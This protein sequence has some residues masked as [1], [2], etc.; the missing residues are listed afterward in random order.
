MSV[1]N[2]PLPA[3]HPTPSPPSGAPGRWPV[4]PNRQVERGSSLVGRGPE[5]ARVEGFVARLGAG[6]PSLVLVG[7]AGIGKTTLWRHGVLLARSAGARV[8]LAR[9]GE[10]DRHSPAQG[11]LDLFGATGPDTAARLS[12]PD[13][14]V[15]ERSRLVLDVLRRLAGDVP[16]V[17][18]VDD[19]PWLDDPTGRALRFAL[20]RLVDEPVALLATARTWGP[21]TNPLGDVGR[22]VETLV[23]DP[24]PPADL[25]RI[26]MAAVPRATVPLA[27][28]SGDLARGNP[29]LAIE[30]ARARVAGS[31]AAPEGSALA[32]VTRRLHQLP[33]PALA[34]ARLLAVAGPTGLPVL[35]AASGSGDLDDALRAGLDGDAFVLEPDFVLRFAH[36]LLAAAVL[37]GLNAVDRRDLHAA[38]AGVVTDPDERAAHLA[39]S[40]TAPDSGVAGEVEAAALRL[41]RRGAP[42]PAADLL[43]HSAR[44]TPPGEPEAHLRRVLAQM[45]QCATAGDLPA[46]LKLAGG[47]LEH[48]P[49]GPL[50]AAAVTGRVVL[51]FSDG[52]T[53]LREALSG[54]PDDGDPGHERLRG[55]LLG[56]LGWLLAVHLGRV[57]EGLDHAREGLRIGR[58]HGD[59]VLVA[60]AASAVSTAS[61]VQG[62]RADDLVDEAVRLGSEVVASHLALWPRVLRGRQRLWDGRLEQ[63][64]C[65]LEA[66]Y[67]SAVASGSEFQ[68]PYRLCDLAHVALAEGDLSR[69][70]REVGEGLEAARDCR[71]ERVESWLAYPAGLVAALRR[72]EDTAEQAADRLRWWATRTGERPRE[73]MAD[74]VRGVQAAAARDWEAALEHLVRSVSRLDDLG[75]VHPG[76]VPVLPPAIEAA[77]LAGRRDDAHA[78]LHALRRRCSGLASPWAD[79]ILASARGQVLLLHDDPAALDVLLDARAR[80]ARTGHALDA[81]RTGVVAA[82][83]A[84]RAGRRRSV[85]E[86]GGDALETFCRNGVRG[87]DGL[88]RELLDRAGGATD[89]ELTATEAEVAAL[90][91]DGLRNREVGVRMFVSEST[92][93]AHLTRIYRKLGVRNRAGLSRHVERGRAVPGGPEELKAS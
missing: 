24:V 19:L 44:L 5:R 23:V 43:S 76:A 3:S 79:A 18:A 16:V 68:R 28:R 65:D 55:R 40:V 11:L 93:E 37:G 67:A 42:Q 64:R 77:C 62:E 73:A 57:A 9:P 41:A 83:A 39:R 10:D 7:D 52:E 35:C 38:L 49:P 87:Y 69:A 48:L 17:L 80:L 60:Q 31:T 32:A 45:K 4:A 58:L 56:L 86:L 91:A 63:A 88:A 6:A 26:V 14:P 53:F 20:R 82:A 8:L 71:D 72:D 15:L 21:A 66:M 81:A 75:Y 27:V 30:L 92:V 34:L 36:P 89:D 59:D 25:R 47:L 1:L 61:L 13:L 46:A 33:A 2:L 29:L 84:L 78:L 90:V 74:H 50:R 12:D 54:V 51:D 70:A 22:D 85:R